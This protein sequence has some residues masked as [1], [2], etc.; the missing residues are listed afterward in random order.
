MMPLLSIVVTDDI[1]Y[2]RRTPDFNTLVAPGFT[3]DDADVGFCD[4]ECSG[5]Q[6]DQV[7]VGLAIQRGC[8]NPQLDPVAQF[9]GKTVTGSAWLNPDIE[10]QIITLPLKK[11]GHAALKNI[12]FTAKTQKTQSIYGLGARQ[13]QCREGQASVVIHR[14]F[15]GAIR[16]AIAPYVLFITKQGRTVRG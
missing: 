4:L 1:R 5:Q 13:S 6:G 9:L 7:P 3:G 2:I 11:H 12:V 8:S 15:I 16:F 10:Q 14:M